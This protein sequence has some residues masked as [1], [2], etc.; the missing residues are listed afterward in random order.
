MT[1]VLRASYGKLMKEAKRRIT[2]LLLVVLMTALSACGKKPEP[3]PTPVPTATPTPTAVPTVVPT[4]T[5]EP[6]IGP[7]AIAFYKNRTDEKL[8]RRFDETFRDRWVAGSEI[9]RIE[10]LAGTEAEIADDGRSFEQIFSDLWN[11]NPGSDTCMIAYRVQIET[12]DGVYF[13]G[14]IKTSE[15][16][17]E[18]KNYIG[19]NLYDLQGR[20]IK[21][22]KNVGIPASVKLT[23]G[24]E[25][26]QVLSP[27]IVTAYVY[28]SDDQFDGFGNYHGK[29]STSVML[30][31]TDTEAEVREAYRDM[32]YTTTVEQSDP[33]EKATA[34]TY[35]AT[36]S[37][38]RDVSAISDRDRNTGLAYSEGNSITVTAEKEMAGIYLIWGNKTPGYTVKAGEQ[39]ITC[40]A[41]GFLHDYVAFETPVKECTVT[42]HEECILC[43]L[44]AYSEGRLPDSVQV[45]NAPYENADML[46]FAAHA[47]D[48]SLYFGGPLTLYGAVLNKRV[49]VVYLTDYTG[50][51]IAGSAREHEKLDCLWAM[52]IH[53]Y[54]VNIAA[55]RLQIS[56]AG[57]TEQDMAGI[58]YEGLCLAVTEQIRRF[59][60][61]VVI[62]HDEGGEYGNDAHVI[63]HRAVTEAVQKTMLE[64]YDPDSASKYG[65]WDVPKT[66]I[67]LYGDNTI[68]MNLRI[69]E[70][71]LNN[72]TILNTLRQ[73]Y[74]KH[75]SQQH[76]W[77]Y[78]SDSNDPA[79]QDY[80]CADFGLFRTTVGKNIGGDMFEH[81]L[82]YDEQAVKQEREE[83]Y[84]E[85]TKE[86]ELSK[87]AELTRAAEEAAEKKRRQEQQE[88]EERF[89]AEDLAREQKAKDELRR[90]VY[91]IIGVIVG[92]IVLYFL[93]ILLL[94]L[95]R[96]KRR[97]DRN[98]RLREKAHEENV[99]HSAEEGA[100]EEDYR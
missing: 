30:F 39:E 72:K 48:E 54:P 14:L 78:V 81:V 28:H 86:A 6:Q 52:G 50:S 92:L 90:T 46:V 17:A 43:D 15:D 66:Y 80:S 94:K 3:S 23:A 18:I 57:P 63:L 33:E 21:T 12:K 77:F 44:Y 16:A 82:T 84:A 37:S 83:Y 73:A 67:H 20:E 62:T 45:W 74:E 42:I 5:P 26:A 100:E 2:A 10:C 95:T 91:T 27:V 29:V 41:D 9:T 25:I 76:L 4:P 38:E 22:F 61:L 75:V 11:Q 65:T 8:R 88:E 36:D 96:L 60:P 79:N 68:R 69:R 34:V 71:K 1:A 51:D 98:R 55:D 70:A 47:S 97:K 53:T 24:T 89:A 7:A 59:K 35:T 64:D 99:K 93:G 32:S 49:Q 85:L 13:N 31:N 19:V 40:G 56:T 58:S 87:Q